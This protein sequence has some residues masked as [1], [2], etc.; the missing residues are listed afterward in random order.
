MLIIDRYI[1]RLFLKILLVAGTGMIGLYVIIDL[2][3]KLDDLTA[4]GA[5]QGSVRTILFE[6]Y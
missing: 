1:T 6:F 2:V 3:G 4:Q 5:S